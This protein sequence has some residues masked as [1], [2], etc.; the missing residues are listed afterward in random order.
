MIVD[1][2]AG[3]NNLRVIAGTL[4][5]MGQIIRINADAVS[6]DKT[7]S[8]LEEIPLG[9]RRGQNIGCIDTKSIED[10][11]QF[12]DQGYIQIALRVSITFAASATL[13]DGAL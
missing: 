7:W 12:V 6:S 5:A 8:K 10:Q 13:I 1:A 9:T 2:P 3:Q 11:R 4:C